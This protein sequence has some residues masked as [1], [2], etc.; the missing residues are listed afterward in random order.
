P[1]HPAFPFAR[2]TGFKI[3]NAGWEHAVAVNQVGQRFYNESAIRNVSS[4][5]KYPPGSDGTRK[6]FTPLDWRNTS[7]AQVRSQ[8]KRSAA[9]DAALAIN[10]GSQPP[11][12]ASGPIWAIFDSAAVQR[13]KWQIRY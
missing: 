1:E 3:G 7:P 5:A 8:Y 10:E 6:E 11:D 13:G 2:A 9:V 4:D 12:F